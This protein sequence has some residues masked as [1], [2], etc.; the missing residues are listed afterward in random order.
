MYQ[1]LLG[2][3]TGLGG[4]LIGVVLALWWRNKATKAEGRTAVLE[5][6]AKAKDTRIADL[7]F[8][9]DKLRDESEEIVKQYK[10]Q[11]S[12]KEAEINV[13]KQ[14]EAKLRELLLQCNDPDAVV[15]RLNQLLPAVPQAVGGSGEAGHR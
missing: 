13:Y 11:L 3:G 1:I 4:T 9:V 10:D 12:R 15:R 8:N 2:V 14:T 6:E 5:S 7:I